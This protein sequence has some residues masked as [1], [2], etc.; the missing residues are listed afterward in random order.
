[1]LVNLEGMVAPTV[2]YGSKTWFQYG[3]SRSKEELFDM[4][5]LRK[6]LGVNVMDKIRN[7]GKRGMGTEV[8]C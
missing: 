3:R 8:V 7:I 4:N 2:S 6:A 1:M 5:C